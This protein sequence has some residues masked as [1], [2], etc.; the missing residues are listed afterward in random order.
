MAS[1]V[2]EAAPGWVRRLNLLWLHRLLTSSIGRKF[3]M[4]ITGL[5]L[6]GFLVIHLAGNLLLYVGPERYDHYAHTLHQQEWLPLAEAG[7]FLFFLLHVYLAFVTTRANRQARRQA[8]AVKVSKRQDLALSQPP[9][10]WMFLSGM[11]VLGFLILHLI[12]MKFAARTDVDYTG[13]GPYAVAIAVLSTPLSASVYMLGTVVLGFHLCH[14]FASAF[15][16]LGLNHPKYTPLIK[17][18][19]WLFALVI[20]AGFFSLPLATWSIPEMRARAAR[21]TVAPAETHPTPHQQR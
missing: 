9:H 1:T 2:A 4:G 18:V 7:L 8:Y 19:S 21:S 15:Q 10:N 13:K 16:S 5:G 11:I 6:C 17:L 14:G 12:D 3:V 20:A